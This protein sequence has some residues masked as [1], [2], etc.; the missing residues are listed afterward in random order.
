MLKILNHPIDT[1]IIA[2]IFHFHVWLSAQLQTIFLQSKKGASRTF[3]N[4]WR[5][6]FLTLMF[7]YVLQLSSKELTFF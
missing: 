6:Q 1:L 2:R 5:G 7:V 4:I 3:S